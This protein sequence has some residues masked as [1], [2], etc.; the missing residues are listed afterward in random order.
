M[1]DFSVIN[2]LSN[3]RQQSSFCS[4]TLLTRHMQS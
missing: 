1:K 2:L 4:E 3:A